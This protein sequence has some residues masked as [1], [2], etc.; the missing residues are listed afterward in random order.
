M[1]KASFRSQVLALAV[2]PAV[3]MTVVLVLFF[4]HTRLNELDSELTARGQAIARQL[5]PACE[6]GVF[7]GNQA[8]LS[9]LASATLQEADVI[10]VTVKSNSGE[11]IVSMREHASDASDD[12]SSTTSGS[13]VRLF[14]API[15]AS[16]IEIDDFAAGVASK[17]KSANATPILLGSVEIEV[18]AVA[19]A[20]QQETILLQSLLLGFIGLLLTSLM[21]LRAARSVSVPVLL[22]AQTVEKIK[23]GEFNARVPT[24]AGGELGMLELGINSM[25]AALNQARDDTAKRAE[26]TLF[27]EQ[28]RAQVTLQS[29]GE[30]VI[31]T[32]AQGRVTFVNAAAE[33]LLGW[34]ATQSIGLPLGDVVC[35]ADEVSLLRC[36]DTGVVDRGDAYRTIFRRDGSQLSVRDSA[37]PVRDRDG[38]IIGMVLILLDVTQMHTLTQELAFQATHDP[39]TGLL[40]RRAFEARLQHITEILSLDHRQHVLCY[41]DLDQFKVVNDTCGHAAGDELLKQLTFVLR[42]RLRRGDTIARLGGDEFGV[43]FENCSVEE[44]LPLA[45]T[46]RAAI[47]AFRFGW[48]GH[49]F[50]IGASVGMVGIDAESGSLQDLMRAADSAC[51]VAKDL[52][53]DRIHIYQPDDLV[54]AKHRGEIQWARLL[55]RSFDENR[56]VLFSQEIHAISSQPLALA[57]NYE[58][59]V[60]MLGDD[61]GSLIP[62]M[63]FI[64]AAE[65]FHLMP[66]LDRWVIRTAFRDLGGVISNVDAMNRCAPRYAINLSGQSLCDPQ[67]LAFVTQEFENASVVPDQICFEITETAAIAN[68]SSAVVVLQSL[69][70]MGCR[71]ALD[72]FGSGLS[73]FGYLK[74]LPVDVLKID[75]SFV[76][77]IASDQV[78]LSMVEAINRIG[79]VMGLVT[80]AEF[81]ESAEILTKLREIGVDYAQGYYLDRPRAVDDV[82]L[83]QYRHSNLIEVSEAVS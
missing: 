67:F 32:D 37:A 72:D 41:V 40:N 11:V 14:Q 65:R 9:R 56:L 82:R 25:A 64:P 6:F 21:A 24:Q 2:L 17:G 19:M 42:A 1:I 78:S 28:V 59:T 29:L 49:V 12:G 34:S 15:I 74:H 61:G 35:T 33:Q 18:S 81:V 20:M 60:M 76:K 7:S 31:A 80:V 50:D 47:S 83:H 53:R 45:E 54:L 4:T 46:L 5:A 51:Y 70:D 39:L 10:G 71:I 57:P 43:I 48:G 55:K 79:H 27:L 8:I 3:A 36:L 26:D 23:N 68:L 66:S 44:A 75:G 13:P 22:L 16:E 73:S 38:N 62:P 63:A 69:R 52:G 77:D 58:I 30:G